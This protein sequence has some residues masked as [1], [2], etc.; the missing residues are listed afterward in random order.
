MKITIPSW[1][2]ELTKKKAKAKLKSSKSKNNFPTLRTNNLTK[3]ISGIASI[4]VV[5]S[6]GSIVLSQIKE[7]I[8]PASVANISS[9]QPLVATEVGS[10]VGVMITVVLAFIVLGYFYGR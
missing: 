10:M 5:L 8:Q 6:I 7:S 9:L 1:I 3:L 4:F 2:S